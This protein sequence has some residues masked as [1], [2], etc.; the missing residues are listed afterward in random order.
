MTS[1]R[2]STDALKKRVN[3]GSVPVILMTVHEDPTTRRKME[4]GAVGVSDFLNIWLSRIW[5]SCQLLKA[6]DHPGGNYFMGEVCC[7]NVTRNAA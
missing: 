6:T 7:R 3:S 5:R 1:I 2:N 4:H